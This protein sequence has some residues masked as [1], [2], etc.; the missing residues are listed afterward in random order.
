MNPHRDMRTMRA[1]NDCLGKMVIAFRWV[2]KGL[3]PVVI[4]WLAVGCGSQ[5]PGEET[6]EISFRTTG[7]EPG[8][9]S[10]VLPL[11]APSHQ[12]NQEQLS[13]A[14]QSLFTYLAKTSP[15]V[16]V[17]TPPHSQGIWRIE[18]IFMLDDCVA[19]Q[20]TEGHFLE[21]LFFVQH[22]EGWRLT[23]RIRPQ[24]HQ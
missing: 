2:V 14:H 16:L 3:M 6:V 8:A 17:T 21:T 19:V 11:V 20:M 18:K 12:P 23:G 1:D 5:P 15:A 10:I 9:I 13:P 24:D 22:S 7:V 4:F